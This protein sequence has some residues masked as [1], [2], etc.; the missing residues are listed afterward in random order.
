MCV[1]CSSSY[2]LGLHPPPPPDYKMSV[3][4]LTGKV[5]EAA[6]R[7]CHQRGA[8]R[9]LALCFVNGGV[10]IKLGQHIGQLVSIARG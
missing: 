2:L 4:S 6:L 3:R 7:E 9:L 5:Y 8:D 1:L 10:Y